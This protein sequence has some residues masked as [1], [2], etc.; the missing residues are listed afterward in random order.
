MAQS[1][2]PTDIAGRT[3]S[4]VIANVRNG[5]TGDFQHDGALI[6][7]V[8]A[9][10]GG[11]PQG[12]EIRRELGRMLH[13]I[14]PDDVRTKFDGITDGFES[15]FEPGLAAARAQIAAGDVQAAR[16]ALEDLIRRYGTGTGLFQDDSVSEY[17]HFA[18]DFELALY[19]RLY[20]PTRQVRKLPLDRAT[21]YSLYGAVLLELQDA[22]GAE[23]A[24]QE[25][26]RVNPIS[27]YAM[28]ELGEVMKLS[29]RKQEC[30][31]LTLRAM[32]VAYT[33]AELGRGYRNLGYLAI[34]DAD[35]DLAVACY[36]MS[37]GIDREHA[38]AAEAELAYIEQVTQRGLDLPDRATVEARLASNGIQVGPSQLVRQLM[39][40]TDDALPPAEEP[41]GPSPD[42]IDPTPPDTAAT[43]Q[44]IASGSIW[45][46]P[47]DDDV[48]QLCEDIAAGRVPM[49]DDVPPV[50]ADVL[51]EAARA[52]GSIRFLKHLDNDG[53]WLL[54]WKR[55]APVVA[56]PPRGDPYAELRVLGV[57][58]LPPEQPK[59]LPPGMDAAMAGIVAERFA[60]VRTTTKEQDQGVARKA[61]FFIAAVVVLA[62][63]TPPV[64]LIVW[65]PAVIF[66]AL[67]WLG[68]RSDG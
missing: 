15:G 27:T 9:A 39:D 5:L 17:R 14:A 50:L 43:G 49:P 31:E 42:V 38:R 34:E 23:A 37:L 61:P 58:G 57:P 56:T 24:L 35:F 67:A 26:L 54:G 53:T 41:S 12:K 18:N 40:A 51:Q 33:P 36:C 47:V 7:S 20:Q 21:L 62:L 46:Q 29:G 48:V 63:V 65:V 44:A 3:Y 19:T 25:A 52:P 59:T 13:S 55:V 11:H 60:N 10:T 28:Y 4:D 2:S 16:V 32:E 1:I 22:G 8:T 45:D 6:M 64:L 68:A 66:L 30:R